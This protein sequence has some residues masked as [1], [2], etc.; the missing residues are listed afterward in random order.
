MS[1][2][3]HTLLRFSFLFRVSFFNTTPIGLFLQSECRPVVGLF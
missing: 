3:P 2:Q 1:E